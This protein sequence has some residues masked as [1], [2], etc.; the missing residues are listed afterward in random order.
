[1]TL[2]VFDIDD[3]LTKSEDHHQTALITAMNEMGIQ[4]INTDWKSYE[5]LTDSYI[6]HVNY[7]QQFKRKPEP[8]HIE[9][10]DNRMTEII[11]A[12]DPVSEVQGAGV[13]I[14]SIRLCD[15]FVLAF[16]TGSFY[17]PAVLKLEQAGIWHDRRLVAN[18][19]MLHEREQIV[20]DAIQRAKSYYNIQDF[21]RVISIGDGIWDFKTARNLNL[22]FIG[23]GMNYYDDFMK[24]GVTHHTIDWE[25]VNVDQLEKWLMNPSR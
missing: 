14:D 20:S 10:L 9:Q 17:K 21:D 19:N 25:D 2:F 24:E 1:M 7:L 16:A 23:V 6:F 22:Q 11:M 13:L 15:H 3:T 18:S 5:H 4:H 12:L 8:T